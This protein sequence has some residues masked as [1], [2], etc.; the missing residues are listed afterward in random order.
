VFPLESMGNPQ[1]VVTLYIII[2]K[3]ANLFFK[4]YIMKIKFFW[5]WAALNKNMDNT[6]FLIEDWENRLQVDCG[7]WIWLAQRV[8]KTEAYFENI[9]ITHKHSD[10]F[11]W[12][13]HL[14]RLFKTNELKKL[15][16]FS[17]KDV[18]KTI[19]W[20]VELTNFS[21]WIK[22]L[23]NW[24]ISFK[25]IDNLEKQSIWDFELEPI[26]LNSKKIEQFG[27]LLKYKWK[28]ILFFWDEAI[29]VLNRKDLEKFVWVDYLICEALNLDKRDMKKWWDIDL[30]KIC[31]ISAKH[32][33]KIA[34]K[35]QVKNLI[36]VH[37][38]EFENRQELLKNDAKQE[39]N[40]NIIVPNQWDIVE[41]N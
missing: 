12:F 1:N 34:K 38:H 14:P 4:K 10:H 28:K 21:A 6:Y 22:Y 27:F 32:A 33:G 5:V 18:E 31:H 25:N 30:E 35:L 15:T 2:L 24:K 7:W 11:Y 39:F 9:F 23:W 13:F 8:R 41:I 37:T 29:W 17:S 16:V 40:W 19:R 20:I 3:K 26:N 36:L